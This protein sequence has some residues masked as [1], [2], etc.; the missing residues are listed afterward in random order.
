MCVANITLFCMFFVQAYKY[1]TNYEI[2]YA[3]SDKLVFQELLAPNDDIK[4]YLSAP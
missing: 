4:S 2:N 1:F 3:S